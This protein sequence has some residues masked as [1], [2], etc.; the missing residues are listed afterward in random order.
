MS[1]YNKAQGAG[2][3]YAIPGEL[4]DEYTPALYNSPV[5]IEKTVPLLRQAL[6][7]NAVVKADPVMGGEDF[8]RYGRTEE[9][10]PGAMFKLGVVSQ[11]D[12]AAAQRGELELPSLH[13]SLLAPDARPAISTGVE[14][15]TAVLLGLLQQGSTL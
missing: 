14:G 12:H 10:I 6:G 13:S 11:A 3:V 1:L 2:M 15:M 9:N 8:G 5:L 4:K 7:N